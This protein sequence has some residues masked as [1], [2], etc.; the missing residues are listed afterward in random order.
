MNEIAKLALL[1]LRRVNPSNELSSDIVLFLMV[2]VIGWVK[3]NRIMNNGD[4]PEYQ[5]ADMINLMD[6]LKHISISSL[7]DKFLEEYG[8]ENND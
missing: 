1:A 5:Q 7:V 8:Y 3:T 6:D 2:C 4:F